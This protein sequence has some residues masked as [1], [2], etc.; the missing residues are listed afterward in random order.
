MTSRCRQFR[1]LTLLLAVAVLAAACGGD[2]DEGATGPAGAT[3]PDCLSEA[4]VDDRADED[5]QPDI[6]TAVPGDDIATTTPPTDTGASEETTTTG[7]DTAP[8]TTEAPEAPTTTAPTT[9]A[10]TTAPPE[11]APPADGDVEGA[12]P[13]LA[14]QPVTAP[15]ATPAAPARTLQ[16]V[17]DPSISMAGSEGGDLT[18]AID[19]EP[20]SLVPGTRPGNGPWARWLIADTHYRGAVTTEPDGTIVRNPDLVDAITVVSED[21]LVVEYVIGEAADWSDGTPVTGADLAFTWEAQRD[22]GAANAPATS[23]GYAS[24]A[25]IEAAD[26]G[27][28][29]TVT[30]D[31]PYADW[32][33]LFAHVY[34]RHVF[35]DIGDGEGVRA[36]R[37]GVTAD[38]LPGLPLV[39]SG[40]YQLAQY[41]AGDNLILQ[42]NPDFAGR[43]GGPDRIL[44]LFVADAGSYPD[45]LADG[46]I[47]LVVAPG[48]P[49][50]VAELTASGDLTTEVEYGPLREHLQ[51][52]VANPVF[53]IPEVRQAVALALDRATLAEAATDGIGDGGAVLHSHV[54]DPDDAD[55]ADAAGRY[56]DEDRATA[57]QLLD[58]LGCA[59]GEIT[60]ELAWHGPDVRRAAVAELVA[61]QLGE[62]GLD[63]EL[64]P[65]DDG[66]FLTTGD[67]D[68]ALHAG[69]GND[70]DG[71]L[72]PTY[73]TG[74]ARNVTGYTN[75]AVDDLLLQAE[76]ELDEGAR[77]DLLDEVDRLLWEDLPTIPL[78]QRPQVL[79]WRTDAVAGPATNAYAGPLWNVAGW[80]VR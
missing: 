57:R 52:N 74:G 21:P 20:T 48:A 61:A 11:T 1:S 40:P 14:R 63:V 59:D 64:R 36:F 24:I 67:F 65:E 70:P 39:S 72:T 50:L 55:G 71:A 28:T 76:A 26:A 7:P 66:E 73:A 69:D 5:D 18:L 34:P 8:E 38:D 17:P 75:A 79:A 62:V 22:P 30:F 58:D 13:V 53:R 4:V 16:D 56:G 43:P 47:D 3:T 60:L 6:G 41:E 10:P 12:L 77:A 37:E 46:D 27:K 31:Q 9:V 19:Q 33:S 29:V 35:D 68:L 45:A 23:R 15:V 80:T 54:T 44:G 78:H 2:D 42:R 25:D 32:P 51:L 49:D